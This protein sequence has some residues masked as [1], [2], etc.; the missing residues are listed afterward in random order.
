MSV[1]STAIIEAVASHAM[2]AG[3]AGG[4]FDQVNQYEPKS[5]PGLG[6]AAAI[7]VQDLRPVPA[8][9]GL[10]ISSARLLL[11]VRIYS[12]MLQEPQDMIDP[13]MM[14]AADALMAAYSGDFTL[15]GMDLHIDLLGSAGESLGGAAGYVNIDNAIFRIFT[16]TV[17][18]IVKD[19]YEQVA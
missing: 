14:E 12:N 6:L 5:K 8:Y 10:H 3:S 19:V 16:I 2:A 7:W 4:Y 13:K 9:S 1:D 11:N 17:P 18:V 15:D